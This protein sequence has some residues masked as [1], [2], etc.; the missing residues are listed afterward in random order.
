MATST[1]THWVKTFTSQAPRSA[2]PTNAGYTGFPTSG[3]TQANTPFP[4][5]RC[6][7]NIPATASPPERAMVWLN[8][9]GAPAARWRRGRAV[10]I[11][12]DA[13]GREHRTT[14]GTALGSTGT[15]LPSHPY[16]ATSRLIEARSDC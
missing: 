5:W 9:L 4:F 11:R 15:D 12:V 3:E 2:A 14:I 16:L 10:D 7:A 8:R 1:M 13:V 6:I